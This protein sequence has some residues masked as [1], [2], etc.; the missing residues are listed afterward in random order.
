MKIKVTKDKG[1]ITTNLVINGEEIQFDYVRLING[2]YDNDIIDAIDFSEDIEEWEREE[3]QKLIDDINKTVIKHDE[4][5][6]TEE[7]DDIDDVPF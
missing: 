6:T 5:D 7:T 4:E 3:I 1:D 2:L